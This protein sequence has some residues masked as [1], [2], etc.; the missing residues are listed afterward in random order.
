MKRK[1]GESVENHC[2]K[3]AKMSRSTEKDKK[4]DRQLRW[5]A[6]ILSFADLSMINW[7]YYL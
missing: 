1:S 2:E 3:P 6:H 5:V 7:R 4:Y